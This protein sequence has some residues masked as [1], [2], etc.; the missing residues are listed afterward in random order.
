MSDVNRPRAFATLDTDECWRLVGAHGVGRVVFAGDTRP[1][2]VP[3]TYDA[4]SRTAYFRAPTF[5]QLARRADGHTISLCVDDIDGATLTGWSVQIVGTAHRVDDSATVASLWSLGRPHAWFPGTQ[6][7]WIALP[8]D[9]VHG[10][11]VG[12]GTH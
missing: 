10:Q 8:V 4:L 7:Q 5:G 3:T 2:V 11:R 12:D 1:H 9:Q 6:T